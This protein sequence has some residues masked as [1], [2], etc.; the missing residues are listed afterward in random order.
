MTKDEPSTA[1][2]AAW[3]RERAREFEQ[4]ATQ[5]ESVARV[6]ATMQETGVRPSPAPPRTQNGSDHAGVV[7]TRM[8]DFTKRRSMRIAEFA[9]ELGESPEL[10]ERL[11]KDPGNGFESPG[12]GWWRYKA[13]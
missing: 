9:A 3:L 8:R 11:L 4:M 12:Q 13:Q 6:M 2:V 1:L 10:I 5:I 7:L